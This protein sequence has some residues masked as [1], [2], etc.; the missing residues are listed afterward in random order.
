MLVGSD[1]PGAMVLH[2]QGQATA[3][4]GLNLLSLRSKH[5]A[6]PLEN[7]FELSAEWTWAKYELGKDGSLLLSCVTNEGM[8]HAIAAGTLVGVVTTGGGA[9]VTDTPAKVI[10]YLAQSK[11]KTLWSVLER[12]HP[13][14]TP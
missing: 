5:F 9:R 14:K 2:Y 11:D 13:L 10:A 3:V 1:A 7:K 4:N 8:S 6:D 12:L